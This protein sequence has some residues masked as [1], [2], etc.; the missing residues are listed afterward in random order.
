MKVSVV[1]PCLNEE[2]T[3]AACVLEALEA[4]HQAGLSGEVLVVDNGSSDYTAQEALKHGARVV[5]AAARGYGSAIA[6]GVREATGKYIFVADGDCSYDFKEIPGFIAQ[7]EAGADLVIGCRASLYGGRVDHDAMPILHRYLGNPILTILGR[8][9]L[10]IPSHDL[11]CGM[12]AFNR[13]AFL[14]M[15]IQSKG[16]E[17]AVE[18]L[19]KAV[20]SGLIFAERPIT[21]R[22]DKRGRSS[23]LKTWP[24][25]LKHLWC[26]LKLCW[27]TR[28]L[29][30]TS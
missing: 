1:I 30:R 14:G 27:E 22:K 11:C 15:K 10:A 2:Q 24:D 12:R 8:L 26:I 16:M 19:A 9:L 25:G 5:N 28:I 3:V 23:H 29:Q 13:E 18:M 17:F 21:L 4:L 7:L 6:H 20:Q